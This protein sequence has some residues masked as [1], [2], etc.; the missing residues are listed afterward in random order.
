MILGLIVLAGASPMI[1]RILLAVVLALGV[2][3]GWAVPLP[4]DRL[5]QTT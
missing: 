4:T 2:E 5:V 3:A 1:R